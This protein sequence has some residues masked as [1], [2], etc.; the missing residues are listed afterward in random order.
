M[1]KLGSHV[2]M[3]APDYILGSVNEAL[4]YQANTFML[5]TGAPQ[6]SFRT[7]IDKLM[8]SEGIS[9]WTELGYSVD[10]I[11]VHLPYTIN[12]ANTVKKGIYEMGMEILA[13]ELTRTAAIGARYTVLHPGSRLTGETEPSL[14][15]V[16]QGINRV[17][18]E[19]PGNTVICLETMAGKGSEIGRTFEEIRFIIDGIQQQ[20]RI[21]VCLDTCHIHDGGYDLTAFDDV[22]DEFDRIIG[23]DRLYVIHINDSK[24]ERGAHKDRHANI[25]EGM[26]GFDTINS[27][28]HNARLEGIP[29][30]LETPY[31]GGNAPYAREIRM[32]REQH[33]LASETD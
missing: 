18:S 29:M 15:Q 19:N 13:N 10:D 23:L 5:Y 20:D 16:S 6:N 33:Y 28:V 24:N 30:I 8:I 4:S 7:S 1:I 27:I 12:L 25:G 14:N 32:L 9:K 3:S 17:L 2:G 26:I 31:I 11:I 21:G 22:L